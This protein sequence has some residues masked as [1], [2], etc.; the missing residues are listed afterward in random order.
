MGLLDEDQERLFLRDLYFAPGWRDWRRGFMDDVGGPPNVS[1]GG[2]YNYRLAWQ[3]GA[4]PQRDPA[5]GAFHGLSS[6]RVPPYKD[7]VPLKRE[8]HPTAWK[9]AFWK[10]FG[11][12]PDLLPA[13]K[14]TPEMKNWFEQSVFRPQFQTGFLD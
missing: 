14:W 1:P 2:D 11:A 13:E 10:T 7:P 5:S 6:A 8:D 12:N 9:E 4:V 3:A